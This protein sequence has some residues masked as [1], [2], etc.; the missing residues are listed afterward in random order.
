MGESRKSQ[1]DSGEKEEVY[2]LRQ[3]PRALL[4]LLE[5]GEH[6]PVSV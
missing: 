2:H 5:L 3:F 1:E 6:D 4:S